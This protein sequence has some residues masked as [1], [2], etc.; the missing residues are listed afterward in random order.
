LQ[1]RIIPGIFL[2]SA[3]GMGLLEKLVETAGGHCHGHQMLYL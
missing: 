3:H 1:E 2:L